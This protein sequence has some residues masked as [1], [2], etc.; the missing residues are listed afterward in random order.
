M[1]YF[2]GR[3]KEKASDLI[4]DFHSSIDFD[5][6]LYR[7]DIMGSIAHARML[8]HKEIIPAEDAKLIE[9]TLKEILREIE[10]GKIPFS[11]EYE[12]IHM[13]I[14]KILT[15]RIGEPG[16]KLHTA[17]SRND[18]IAVD[19]KLFAKDE[20]M[21]VRSQL[22]DMMSLLTGLAKDHTETYMPGFTHL[23]KAQPVTFAH[24]LMAYAEMF[25]RDNLR[26]KNAFELLD[27]CPLG[28][29][30]LAGVT[31][32]IDREY[33]AKLLGFECPNWNSLDGVS[34]RDYLVELMNAFALIMVHMSRLCEEIVI[35]TSNDYGYLELS[36]QFA[37]GSSIMP[38]KKN[39]DA[40][41]L[42]R[43]KCGRVFGD[44][45]SL[46][47]TLKGIPL[48]YNKDLQED[49][50]VFFDALD[51][52]KGCLLVLHGMLETMTV[53]KET[54]LAAASKGFMGATDVADYLTKKG[55]SFRDAYKLVGSMVTWCM[56]HGYTLDNLPLEEYKRFSKL[57]YH[58]IYKE[59]AT[60]TSVERRKSPGGPARKSVRK[61]IQFMEK[62]IRNA[63][64]EIEGYKLNDIL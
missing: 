47:T 46:L 59:I 52:V 21:K 13:N 40:A 43:G 61:H 5:K 37:T 16:K 44:L 4:L 50:E 60:E 36:D 31:Y 22:L 24:Y 7:Y 49:K 38:Q 45:Q 3:F 15:D 55:M 17:R 53:R 39:P 18:Q 8:A 62:F 11:R 26:I 54:M 1:Q 29:A 30:A 12:D 20:A 25:R 9:K 19:M 10:K 56:D 64:P 48:A 28:S 42:I 27:A 6:R 14:E 63:A 57:F 51:T 2:S 32:P 35:F 41:E 34:D 33:T 23:Q 58:D